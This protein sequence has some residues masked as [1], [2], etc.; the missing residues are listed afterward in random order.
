MRLMNINIFPCD[1]FVEVSYQAP[2]VE[3]P[4]E[5]P[6]ELPVGATRWSYPLEQN[7]GATPSRAPYVFLLP[8]GPG[9]LHF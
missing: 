1:P 2:I 7:L 6:V 5:L 4:E 3:L 9:M 8:S